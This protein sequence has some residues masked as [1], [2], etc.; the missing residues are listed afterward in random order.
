MTRM[1]NRNGIQRLNTAALAGTIAITA[2]FAV[3]ANDESAEP[4]DSTSIS[5]PKFKTLRFDENWSAFDPESGTDYWDD[6]KHIKL[7]DDGSSWVGVGGELRIRSETWKSFGFSPAT[8]AD[9]SFTLARAQLYTDWHFGDNLRVFVEGESAVASDRDLA[10][11]IRGLDADAIDLQNA[12]VDISFP[13]GEKDDKV[14]IRMGRQ[15]LLFGKQRL[16][17][18]LPW[19]NSQRSWDGARAIFNIDGW[20]IDAFYTRYTPVEKYSF[21]DW[22]DGPDFWGVYATGKFGGDKNIGIDLYY[23]GLETDGAKAYN[24]TT[25]IEERHTIGARLFGKFG[26]SGFG[27]DVEGAY[28]FGDVGSADISAYMFASQVYYAFDSEWKPKVYIG[29][30]ISSGDKTAGDGDVETFNQLF[31]L[32]HAY[33]GYM[34]LIGRQNITDISAGVSFMPHKKFLVKADLHNF[35]RTEDTDSVYNAGGGILRAT[36]PGASGSVG[37]EL[38]FT[39]KYLVDRHLTIQGGYSHFFADDFFTDTGADDDIDFVYFQAVYKF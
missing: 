34:D 25:G 39:V 13:F 16:V 5:Y 31:P 29:F 20:R 36:A 1:R 22:A 17:S 37:Q 24:G 11:G 12:F 7:N 33:N 30:D 4:S 21:N 14:T 23:L 19:S 9:D 6:I 38:D 32:G 35:T 27:Y 18:T 15:G 8:T 26:D 28:Q 10:G 2:G 3:A